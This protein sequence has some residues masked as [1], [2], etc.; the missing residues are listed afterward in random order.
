MNTYFYNLIDEDG[1]YSMQ[2][3]TDKGAESFILDLYKN[4]VST[5]WRS[6]KTIY[7]KSNELGCN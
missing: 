4:K 6:G 2:F 1:I 5:I 7:E 3:H